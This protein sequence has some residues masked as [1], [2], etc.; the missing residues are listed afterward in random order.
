LSEE[1][2]GFRVSGVVQG[3][4][5]RYWTRRAGTELGLRGAVRNLRDGAV[6]V[7]VSGPADAVATLERRLAQGPS[8]A[9][10]ERVERIASS[11]PIPANGF[12]IE[13]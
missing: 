8:G 10:V 13:R 7:H 6:E 11:L 12:S 9:R 1:R 3:V 5:F 4:G 2:V